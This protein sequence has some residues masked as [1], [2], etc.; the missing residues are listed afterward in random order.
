MPNFPQGQSKMEE[1]LLA[2]PLTQT[3]RHRA[4]VLPFEELL[5]RRGPM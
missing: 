2:I 4:D 3:Q 1:L 5:A